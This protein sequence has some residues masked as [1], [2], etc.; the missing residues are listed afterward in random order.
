MKKVFGL[1][2]G[3]A[4]SGVVVA[5]DLVDMVKRDINA[6]RRTIVAEAMDIATDKQTEFWKTY[7][8]LEKELSILMDR[9]VSNISK[10]AENYDN[11]TDDIADD[12][13]NSYFEI[14]GKR[15]KLY[16]TYYKKLSKI[17]GKKE[18]ARFVQLLGQ[19]QLIIDMQVAAELPLIE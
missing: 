3:L 8:E 7:N 15:V 6:E 10:F 19:I 16:K 14:H 11:I 5:Q 12:L 4:I 2:F 13:S 1:I 17:I 18:A 9:R